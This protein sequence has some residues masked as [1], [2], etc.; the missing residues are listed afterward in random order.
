MTEG[1]AHLSGSRAERTT[2]QATA[3][4]NLAV[5]ANVQLHGVRQET[6]KAHGL[7]LSRQ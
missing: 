1:H 3:F 2:N 7:D 6:P 4:Q 5:T